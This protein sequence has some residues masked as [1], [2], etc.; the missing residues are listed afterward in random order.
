MLVRLVVRP[1]PPHG[2]AMLHHIKKRFV[3]IGTAFWLSFQ[4]RTRL[5]AANCL[6]LPLSFYTYGMHLPPTFPCSVAFINILLCCFCRPRLGR[7]AADRA[8]CCGRPPS[9]QRH[10]GLLGLG[11]RTG[12]ML[13]L[14]FFLVVPLLLSVVRTLARARV[15][16]PAS[17]RV[18]RDSD[19]ITGWM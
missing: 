12:E 15:A 16:T 19:G 3:C 10:R 6:I 17:M 2:G 4:R 1:F 13:F 14:F 11:A 9:G 18:P 8:G 5:P 7:P